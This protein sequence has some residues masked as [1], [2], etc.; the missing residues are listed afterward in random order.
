MVTLL[1]LIIYFLFLLLPLRE[2][3]ICAHRGAA[4]RG[5]PAGLMGSNFEDG[6]GLPAGPPSKS[7]C[8]P[9]FSQ[10]GVLRSQAG[11]FTPAH[12]VAGHIGGLLA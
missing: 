5:Q 2:R 8:T 10:M 12:P 4:P 9:S 6:S 3:L 11:S 7:F 1:T